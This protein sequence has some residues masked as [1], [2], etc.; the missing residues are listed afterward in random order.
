MKLKITFYKQIK[1]LSILLFVVCF[2]ILFFIYLDINWDL[3]FCIYVILPLI[4]IFIGPV[5]IIHLN[6]YLTTKDV[7]YEI[8]QN[9]LVIIKTTKI[10]SYK[11]NE[12]NEIVLYMTAN[13]LKDSASRNFLYENYYYAKIK[14]FNNEEAIITCL[15]SNK[16]DQILTT[17]FNAV[18]ILKIKRFYPII[19]FSIK[20]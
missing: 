20:H 17:N 6:Y 15:H 5:F 1:I 11:T 12:I 3:K 14:L 2:F 10:S 19:P 4:L 7:S 18:K 13:K 9:E 8:N 16:I